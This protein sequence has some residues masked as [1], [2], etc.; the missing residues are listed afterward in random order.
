MFCYVFVLFVLFFSCNFPSWFQFIF[1]SFNC[2]KFNFTYF[3]RNYDNYSMFRD[4]PG[5]SGMFRDVPCSWFYRR[6]AP[7]IKCRRFLSFFQR[8]IV[9]DIPLSWDISQARYFWES[10]APFWKARGMVDSQE[11]GYSFSG[12][13]TLLNLCDTLVYEQKFKLIFGETNLRAIT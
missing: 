11:K 5:C 10:H 9:R 12:N 7:V 6:P 4:V 1:V 13:N 2:W 3:S 8:Y